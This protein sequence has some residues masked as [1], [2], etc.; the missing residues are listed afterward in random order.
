MPLFGFNSEINKVRLRNL[1]SAPGDGFDTSSGTGF[2]GHGILYI[3]GNKAYLKTTTG[4]EVELG[5]A[6]DFLKLD[7]TAA[8]TGE[9]QTG[10]NAVLMTELAGNPS[11]PATG[12][13]KLYTKSDGLYLV[14][15]TGAVTGPFIDTGGGGG[16]INSA[17]EM[18]GP[19]SVTSVAASGNAALD[20]VAE[21]YDTDNYIDLGTDK[22]AFDIANDGYYAFKGEVYGTF[23]TGLTTGGILEL[24]LITTFSEFGNVIP[25]GVFYCPP[26]F[27]ADVHLSVFGMG[28]ID[29]PG[30]AGIS[31]YSSADEQF[32]FTETR[33]KLVRLAD[34]FV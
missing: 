20:F 13:W 28:N 32:N 34:K 33:L 17:A 9:L 21:E 7:G 18:R 19:D 10:Q 2:S 22:F 29:G 25:T 3:V 30:A 31:I 26:G 12:K 1:S 4:T 15:D 5:S 24:R 27:N 6:G 14:D 23:S 16:A 11:T 8:M